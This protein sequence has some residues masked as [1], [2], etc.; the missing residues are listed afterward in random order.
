MTIADLGR[1]MTWAPLL[2]LAIAAIGCGETDVDLV[3]D[4]PAASG[5][6]VYVL[7]EGLFGAGNASLWYF[8]A[9]TGDIAESVFAAAN[10]RPLGDTAN[11]I[12]LHEGKLWVVVN[13]SQTI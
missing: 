9:A 12:A 11:D 13:N 6:G 8:D 10:S 1:R 7:N 5:T 4:T 2:A 3:D